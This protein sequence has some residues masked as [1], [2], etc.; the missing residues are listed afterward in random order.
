MTPKQNPLVK[1][2]IAS[3]SAMVF[4]LAFSACGTTPPAPDDQTDQQLAVLE[5]ENAALKAQ[6]ARTR[7]TARS[8]IER[9]TAERETLARELRALQTE[10]QT[11][12]SDHESARARIARL[13]RENAALQELIDELR[14]VI[15]LLRDMNRTIE[16]QPDTTEPPEGAALPDTVEPDAIETP[17]VTD[18]DPASRDP[19]EFYTRGKLLPPRLESSPRSP[20]AGI[21]LVSVRDPATDTFRYYSARVNPESENALYFVIEQS[22]RGEATLRAQIRRTH[23]AG[24]AVTEAIALRDAGGVVP[25]PLIAATRVTDGRRWVETISSAL[26]EFERVVHAIEDES[27]EMVFHTTSRDGTETTTRRITAREREAAITV[28]TAFIELGGQLAAIPAARTP[29]E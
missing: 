2:I 21:G 3:L 1:P 6:L 14:L 5:A 25:L 28:I 20:I 7:E 8:E 12:S 17:D 4:A 18:S 13:E 16:P 19:A 15:L 11:V 9:V 23:E 10:L 22:S 27:A 29:R 24:P 26:D